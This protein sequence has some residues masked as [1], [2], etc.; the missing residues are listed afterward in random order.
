ML[1]GTTRPSARRKKSIFW[2]I[3]EHLGLEKL[4]EIITSRRGA[5][6]QRD[7]REVCER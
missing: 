4:F 5:L 3:K 6:I 7:G 1:L 2:K